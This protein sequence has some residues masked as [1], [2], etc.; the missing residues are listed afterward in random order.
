MIF[1]FLLSSTAPCI[2]QKIYKVSK[3]QFGTVVGSAFAMGGTGYLCEKSRDPVSLEAFAEL[4]PMAIPRFDRSV[5]DNYSPQASHQSD[6]FKNGAWVAPFT[7]FLS[8][9]G[10]ANA[11]EIGAMYTEVLTF[12]GGLTALTK[13]ATGRYRPYT[14]NS[15]VVQHENPSPSTRRSFFSGHVSHV[16]SLSFFTATV[17]D[18]LYPDS[19]YKYLV[20]AGAIS[21]P[22]ITGYLRVKAGRHFRSDVIVGY[23]V[24]A[25]IGYLIPQMHKNSF[26]SKFEITGAD[27]GLGLVYKF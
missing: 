2:S 18:D 20:W 12:N 6:Y 13:G 21:A 11:L 26:K 7:L 23:A 3:A 5:I 19:N 8:K 1:L 27:N 9:K 4:D 24:G 14:Y 22:A 16:A 17:F 25:A 15:D 10:R